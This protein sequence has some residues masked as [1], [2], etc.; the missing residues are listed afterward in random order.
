MNWLDSYYEAVEFFYW[1]P[2]HIG[3]KKHPTAGLDSLDKVL[4]R[5]RTMEVTLNH[6]IHQFFLLAP[7]ALRKDWFERVFGQGFGGPF[8]LHGRNVDTEFT[9]ENSVQ[10]DFLFV[11]D[12]EVV[13]IEMKIGA[14]CSVSQILKYALLGLAVEM[15]FNRPLRHH[16]VLLGSGQFRNQ[17]REQFHSLADLRDAIAS[18]DLAAFIKKQPARFQSRQERFGQIVNQMR[19]AFTSYQEFA[20]FLRGVAPAET[21]QSPGAE[22]YRNLTLGVVDE[23]KRRHLAT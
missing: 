12:D 6:N 3:R 14:K 20:A 4:R 19:L 1:E 7:I 13:S 2:Q 8:R 22:V 18:A 21:D 17:W 15:R 5:L 23:L 16:L 11:S 10:P 9:L